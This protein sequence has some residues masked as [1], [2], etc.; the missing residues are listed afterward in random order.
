MYNC[1]KH[2]LLSF[3]VQNTYRQYE[4]MPT[5][6]TAIVFRRFSGNHR[7]GSGEHNFCGRITGVDVRGRY[8][9]LHRQ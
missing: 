1:S 8:R 7:S 2:G 6:E 9:F 4:Y 3:T 5:E